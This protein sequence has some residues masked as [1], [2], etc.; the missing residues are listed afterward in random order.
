MGR[1]SSIIATHNIEGE[2]GPHVD[3][4]PVSR[5]LAR[6]CGEI[7]KINRH[8]K[9]G[10][11]D[12]GN[13]AW[14]WQNSFRVAKEL[15]VYMEGH[16]YV[17]MRVG[18][19]DYSTKTNGG[20]KFMVYARTIV[21]DKFK[22]HRDQ[23]HMATAETIERALKNVKKYMR[24]YSPVECAD[25]SY[26]SIRSKFLEVKYNTSSNS[27]S[28]KN[29]VTASGSLRTELFHM[30]D[31]GYEFL[32][33]EFRNKIVAWREKY[34]ENQASSGRALHAY[35]VHVRI[36]RDEMMCDVIEALDVQKVS[37]IDKGAPTVTYKMNELPEHIA[38][39]LAALSMVGD[40]H[41][42]DGV[43]LRVNSSTFW[44]QR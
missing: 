20:S 23:Y 13:N 8:A 7:R 14:E 15:S 25:L 12:S 11:T 19:G 26:G 37:C 6:F 9:F 17:L 27:D 18:V 2:P 29:G 24:P 35:Y 44:V 32:S 30:L 1:L 39:N 16:A 36:D 4:I 33:L 38:G 22:E 43:G 42:V 28:A 40:D 31:V 41:Y 3:G 21:N 10:V 34:N 5:E